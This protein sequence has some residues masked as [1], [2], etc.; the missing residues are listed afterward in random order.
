MVRMPN[1]QTTGFGRVV[2]VRRLLSQMSGDVTCRMKTDWHALKVLLDTQISWDFLRIPG[3][4]TIAGLLCQSWKMLDP[5]SSKKGCLNGLW[6]VSRLMSYMSVFFCR[7]LDH[8]A[9]QLW[10]SVLSLFECLQVVILAVLANPQS[11][12]LVRDPRRPNA[13]WIRKFW[14]QKV[15]FGWQEVSGSEEKETGV[16]YLLD[17]DKREDGS[18]PAFWKC[19]QPKRKATWQLLSLWQDLARMH[20]MFTLVEDGQMA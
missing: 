15:K 13:N 17:N 14:M 19:L 7:F 4:F 12:L 8:F 5:Q 9:N 16:V 10:I 3:S 6:K 11:Q 20:R 1:I 18:E 2:P